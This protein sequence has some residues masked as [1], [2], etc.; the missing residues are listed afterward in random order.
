MTDPTPPDVRDGAWPQTTI[1]RF[2]LAKLEAAGMK[3]AAA[4][5]RRTLLRRVTYD[6]TG[7][8][9]TWKATQ[10][11]VNDPTPTHEVFE[12]IVETFLEPPGYGERAA[13]LPGVYQ[14]TH[15]DTRKTKVDELIVNITNHVVTRRDNEDLVS[16]MD[17]LA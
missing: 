12:N 17:N 8:P 13:F 1:D 16:R 10:D 9:P 2:V 11:F 6:L 15:L 5:D 3:L 7:L 14:G 4:A